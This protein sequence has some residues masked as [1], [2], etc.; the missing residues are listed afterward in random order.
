LCRELVLTLQQ[1]HTHAQTHAHTHTRKLRA[2]YTL[3]SLIKSTGSCSMWMQYPI[4][5]TPPFNMPNM[6]FARRP[7]ARQR[8]MVTHS[9]ASFLPHV[10]SSKTHSCINGIALSFP[11]IVPWQQD[12]CPLRTF[13]IANRSS[14]TLVFYSIARW[15]AEPLWW[16]A[17]LLSKQPPILFCIW[18]FCGT[19]SYDVPYT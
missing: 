8:V 4:L 18:R 17:E 11:S 2:G 12:S 6:D 1:A 9:G 13:G 15:L 10:T 14:V 19:Q 7:V 3:G 16:D 5:A